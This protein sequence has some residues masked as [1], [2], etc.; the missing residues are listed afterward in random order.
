MPGLP[1]L[2]AQLY[3]DPKIDRCT[4]VKGA[5]RIRGSLSLLLLSLLTCAVPFLQLMSLDLPKTP[6]V[7]FVVGIG[8]AVGL[9]HGWLFSLGA[10]F[11]GKCT[12][13]LLAGT[14]PSALWWL[15]WWW[16][17]GDAVAVAVKTL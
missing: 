4:S 14:G 11:P 12:S 10:L 8:F 3:I 9:A 6:M 16:R 17:R 7:I 5:Y 1:V 15:L 13:F 2:L